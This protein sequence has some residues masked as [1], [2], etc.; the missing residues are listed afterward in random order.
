MLWSFYKASSATYNYNKA[1]I[2]RNIAP[3]T[4]FLEDKNCSFSR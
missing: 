4:H 2:I 1:A 3:S